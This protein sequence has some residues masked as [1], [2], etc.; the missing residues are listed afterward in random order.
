MAEGVAPVSGPG[1]PVAGGDRGGPEDVECPVCYQEYNQYNKCPRMLECLHVFCTEC[2]QRIQ[3]AQHDPSDP[4]GP[5]AIPCPLCRHLTPLESGD[6]LGL[7]CN[8][9]ILSR[10]PHMALCLPASVA[11]RLA[12]A[13]QRVVFSLEGGQRDTRLIILPTVSLRVQQRQLAAAAPGMLLGGGEED[14]GGDAQQSKRTL[15]CVKMLA[16]VFWVLFVLTCLFCV[17]F[18]PHLKF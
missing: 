14:G 6:P 5:P 11:S 12:A 8:S 15:V 9:L 3:L 1:A 16:V 4:R 10:L 2:L 18:R 17:M 7:P 13:S